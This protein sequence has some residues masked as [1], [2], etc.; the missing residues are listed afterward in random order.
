[1]DAGASRREM[2]T[3]WRLSRLRA[4]ARSPCSQLPSVLPGAVAATSA[5]TTTPVCSVTV[6]GRVDERRVVLDARLEHRRQAREAPS[7]A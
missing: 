7:R 5:G 2:Q 3:P 1:M 6:L 4:I